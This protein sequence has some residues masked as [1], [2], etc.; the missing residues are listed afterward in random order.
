MQQLQGAVLIADVKEF[1]RDLRVLE[2]E[3]MRQLEGETACC[4]VTLAQCHALMELSFGEQ[5]LR[6]LAEA[7]DLDTSTLSRT[8]DGL[9]KAGLVQRTEDP[10]DRRSVRLVLTAAGV[11]RVGRI[12]EMCNRYYDG[13]FLRLRE[14]DQRCVVRAV[15]L[16]A[17]GMRARRREKESPASCCE[18]PVA[19]P[20]R[21]ARAKSTKPSKERAK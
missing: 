15:H 17:H 10:A 9:V 20:R 4:G 6:G 8:V 16:L 14:K 21:A 11:E 1:R 13:L 12:D 3:L 7:V 2:R 18:A 5:S 19:T